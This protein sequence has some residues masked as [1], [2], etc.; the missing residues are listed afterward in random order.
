MNDTVNDP[1]GGGDATQ[2][3]LATLMQQVQTLQQ[4]P[5][6]NRGRK[7]ELT[8]DIYEQIAHDNEFCTT[9]GKGFDNLQQHLSDYKIVSPDVANAVNDDIETY[10]VDGMLEKYFLAK[11]GS[12]VIIGEDTQRIDSYFDNDRYEEIHRTVRHI[13]QYK[14][15]SD[16]RRFFTNKQV[17]HLRYDSQ[18][19]AYRF[20]RKNP[21]DIWLQSGKRIT[22]DRM[23][24][25]PYAP[26]EEGAEQHRKWEEAYEEIG[27]K[28][29]NT[30]ESWG[31]VPDPDPNPEERCKRIL[32]HHLNV[33]C[34]GDAHIFTW[35]TCWIAHK[36]Q[37]PQQKIGTAI[38]LTGG[39][40]CGKSSFIGMWGKIVGDQ[41]FTVTNDT[42]QVTQKFSII[43]EDTLLTLCDESG[44]A[45]ATKGNKF[46][47]F[48][49]DTKVE[50]ERKGMDSKA[51]HNRSDF[52]FCSNELV[53]AQVENGDRRYCVV[54]IKR[55]FTQAD[56]E[57]FVELFRERDN[58][59]LE[60]YYA[61]LLSIDL[62]AAREAGINLKRAPV[63]ADQMQQKILNL[64]AFPKWWYECLTS[65][66]FGRL[67]P[68]N[69]FTSDEDISFDGYVGE[70]I[71]QDAFTTCYYRTL[72]GNQFR[73][74]KE[75]IKMLLNEMCPSL[76]KDTK[77]VTI[78]N[79]IDSP[80]HKWKHITENKKPYAWQLPDLETA[81]KEFET[82]MQGEGL[83]DWEGGKHS[84]MVNNEH[85][86]SLNVQGL[87]IAS[88]KF[89]EFEE[90]EAE[91]SEYDAM[92]EDADTDNI[93][94]EARKARESDAAKQI[95]D[96]EIPF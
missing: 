41:S 44:W 24:F 54:E 25:R 30:F 89:A 74:D 60:A 93:A 23:E 85:K 58:G 68:P 33:I 6:Q 72:K 87:G 95:D 16:L 48:I 9:T 29:K 11:D 50:T 19:Q 52:C 86:Y 66:S 64:R 62:A 76:L 40:G 51:I 94:E 4:Q 36:L 88:N 35:Q 15:D 47:L 56:E 78:S 8:L 39:Q 17:W 28:V 2:A 3:M 55:Q 27:L 45:S 7:A 49:T 61:Y 71:P 82:Y 34:N 18:K 84:Q 5:Q 59:G 42:D 37:R 21:Y 73:T 14:S 96:S 31:C 20:D 81:R 91:I 22:Y 38:A 69:D 26:T 12:N 1:N 83:I 43:K 53:G 32:D 65:G 79:V 10:V 70:W 75:A 13:E 63:T 67:Y 80:T 46:K 77:R 92:F 57:Y 90:Y